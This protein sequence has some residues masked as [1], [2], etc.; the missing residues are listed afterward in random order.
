MSRAVTVSIDA[1]ESKSG[2]SPRVAV[3][4]TGFHSKRGGDAAPDAAAGSADG[5]VTGASV[6]VPPAM[7]APVDSAP[8]SRSFC[9]E[10]A[11]LGG[12]GSSAA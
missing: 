11:S 1:G 2:R 9:A 8:S 3:T 7:D 6:A 12:G 5:V 4:T 10:G